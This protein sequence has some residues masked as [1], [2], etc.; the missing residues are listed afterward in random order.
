MFDFIDDVSSMVLMVY[1]A[2]WVKRRTHNWSVVC[3]PSTAPIVSLRKNI[4]PRCWFVP[5]IYMSK[6]CLFQYPTKISSYKLKQAMFVSGQTNNEK[7]M[8][9]QQL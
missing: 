2:Q 3:N 7:Q 5:V 4:Y 1:D 6:I 8:D 9:K